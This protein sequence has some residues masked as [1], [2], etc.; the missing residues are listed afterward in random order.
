VRRRVFGAILSTIP[1]W[2]FGI[3]VPCIRV[4]CQK[5]DSKHPRP[6]SLNYALPRN[7]L[8][9][10]SK[11]RRTLPRARMPLYASLIPTIPNRFDFV[12][13]ANARRITGLGGGL[14]LQGRGANRAG[15]RP[16]WRLLE[17]TE[18]MG[19]SPLFPI[20]R[21]PGVDSGA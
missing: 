8:R 15:E 14:W 10:R 3:R 7:P 4:P 13:E 6:F 18:E 11:N 12:V 20:G 17:V 1:A 9:P 19:A 16:S 5:R 21:I 2:N